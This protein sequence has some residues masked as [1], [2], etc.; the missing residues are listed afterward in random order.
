MW[1][2]HRVGRITA[3][4]IYDVIHCKSGKSETF[5]QQIDELC[6]CTS[7]LIKSCL[8]KRN[9]G[10]S[11]KSYTDLVKKYHENLM[12]YSTDLHINVKY[13]HLGAS[14]DGIIL[15]YCHG[16]GLLEIKCQQKYRNGL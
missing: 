1:R 11:K 15:C 14:P 2:L 5:T 9:G 3:S 6:S 10:S 13:P 4:N 8:K 7:K 12:A 16:K